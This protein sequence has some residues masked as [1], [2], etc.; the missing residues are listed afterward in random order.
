MASVSKSNGVKVK[1]GSSQG[2]KKAFKSGKGKIYANIPEPDDKIHGS[3]FIRTYDTGCDTIVHTSANEVWINS[4]SPFRGDPKLTLYDENFEPKTRVLLDFCI[5]D[6]T[7][8]LSGDLIVIDGTNNRLVKI[9]PGSITPL[10]STG[11]FQPHGVCIDDKDQIVVG[12]KLANGTTKLAFYSADGS[13]ILRDMEKDSANEALFTHEIGQVKQNGNGDYV[14]AENDRI[15]CVDD[16]SE[17]RWVYRVRKARGDTGDP[18]V[19]GIICDRINNIIV[20]ECG[21]YRVGL[22]NKDGERVGTLL[23]RT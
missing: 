14:V 3:E 12:L 5:L 20:G 17:V 1:D 4:H 7:L 16:K 23:S 9:S 21:N 13:F 15:V 2:K 10:C 22:L 11:A 8:M 19:C 18:H 6:M